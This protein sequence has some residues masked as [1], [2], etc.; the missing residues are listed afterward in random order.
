MT[1][2]KFTQ[3]TNNGGRRHLL[4]FVL[5][6]VFLE[7]VRS[8]FG[9][10]SIVEGDSMCP[11]FRPHD[12]VQARNSYLESQR[13]D[14]VIV[15][16]DRGD[17]VLKRIIGLPGETVTLYGGCVYIDR[18]RLSEPY[19]APH[20]Y[21]FKSD[22][23]N[24]R[25]A[26]WRLGRNQY[27]VLGDNRIASRDSRNFGPVERAA[28]RGLVHLPDNAPRPGFCGI[29]IFKTEKGVTARY[30]PGSNQPRKTLLSAN[31]RS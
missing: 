7:F 23:R 8:S 9:T 25:P 13:G 20:T 29:V 31:S 24:E 1:W 11:T 26:D 6:L 5:G 15:T 14:V 10:Y 22:I 3:W 2:K 18:Q 27:F 4:V 16:D 17:R 19:L 12:I 28:I 21:T 30:N